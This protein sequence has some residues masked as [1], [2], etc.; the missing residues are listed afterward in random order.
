MHHIISDGWSVGILIE[1]L[2]VLYQAFCQEKP[3]PLPKLSI[4]YA[5]F[6]AWQKQWLSGERLETQLNYW[7]QQL[8]GSSELLELPT[9]RPRPAVQI[10]RGETQTFNLDSELSDKLVALSQ[11]NGTTLFMTLY[12]AFA[13]LLHRYSNQSDISIG[14]PIA[15]RN[16]SELESLMGFFVNTLVLLPSR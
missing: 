9:D 14:S 7:K 4:Q 3:T 8:N 10:F 13:T 1:E 12:A 16:R 11:N 15:N 5:D 6:A 2:S